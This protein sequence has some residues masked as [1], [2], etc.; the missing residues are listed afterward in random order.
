MFFLLLSFNSHFI[1]QTIFVY[2]VKCWQVINLL[3]IH[4][5]INQV[6][7]LKVPTLEV[8]S[9]CKFIHEKYIPLKILKNNIINWRLHFLDSI[10]RQKYSRFSL[11]CSKY[12]QLTFFNY[13]ITHKKRGFPLRI[14]SVNVKMRNFFLRSVISNYFDCYLITIFHVFH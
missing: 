12:N 9:K 2:Y 8:L 1:T 7:K 4:L 13:L 3:K 14:S 11:Q 6:N 10:E 5:M